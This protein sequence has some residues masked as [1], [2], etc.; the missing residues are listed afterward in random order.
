MNVFIDLL[1]FCV[2]YDRQYR[3]VQAPWQ[4]DTSALTY[5]IMG[6]DGVSRFLLE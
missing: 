1:N 6:R 5:I 2:N 4:V 3:M